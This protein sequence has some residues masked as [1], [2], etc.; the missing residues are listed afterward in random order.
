V[1]AAAAS[2]VRGLEPGKRAALVISECQRGILDRQFATL[3]HLVDQVEQRDVLSKIAAL[4]DQFRRR[5]LPVMHVHIAHNPGL[6][7][8]SFTSPLSAGIRR[9][10]GLVQGSPQA[11]PMAVVA[12]HPG[13]LV[14][15]RKSGLAMWYGTDLDV[16]LRNSNVDT[17]VMVGVSTNVALFGGSLGAV[18]RGYQVVIAEECTAGGTAETHRFQIANSLPLLAAISSAADVVAALDRH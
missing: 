3:P 10:G 15:A 9:S 16:Q 1:S 2:T 12:P 17:L 14:S 5:A 6:A 18:D 7:G 8:C 4:A 11:E 13:D